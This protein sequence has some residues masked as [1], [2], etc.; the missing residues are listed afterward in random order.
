MY[1]L[2]IK[3]LILSIFCTSIVSTLFGFAGSSIIGTF[4]GWFWVS[5]LVQFIGF[6]AYNS[7]LIQKD[8]IALQQTEIQALEQMSK[9][10]IRLNCAYCNQQSNVP[11]QLNRK[12]TFKCESCNQV[13][14]VSMQFLATTITTPIPSAELP[15]KE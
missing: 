1:I 8:D 3:V 10:V 6:V 11:I 2:F 15:F 4:W 14:G 5:L 12:N 13:N 9:F 7:Y